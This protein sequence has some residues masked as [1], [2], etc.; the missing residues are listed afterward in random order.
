MPIVSENEHDL[1]ECPAQTILC[2]VNTVGVMGSGLAYYFR[3]LSEPFFLKYKELCLT[4]KFT[5]RTLWL[6]KPKPEENIPYWFL[7]FPTKQN[8]TMPSKVEWVEDNLKR[9]VEAIPK[10]GITSLGVP[11]LGCGKGGLDYQKVVRPLLYKYLDPL[12][13]PVHICERK[14]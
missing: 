4:R 3:M 2:P 6:Y 14:F 7:A 1:L 5:I 13:I 9:L 12:D 11:Y 8:W 10:K